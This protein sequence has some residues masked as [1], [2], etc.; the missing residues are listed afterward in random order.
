MIFR[1]GAAVGLDL[2]C[3]GEGADPRSGVLIGAGGTRRSNWP[4]CMFSSSLAAT[5]SSSSM[6]PSCSDA[7]SGTSA[8]QRQLTFRQMHT[9]TN[10]IL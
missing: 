8:S 1:D 3:D 6:G 7:D 4:E 9:L 10:L 2:T 5:L